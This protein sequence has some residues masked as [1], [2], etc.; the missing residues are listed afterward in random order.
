MTELGTLGVWWANLGSASARQE[1]EAVQEIERMGYGTFW[2]GESMRNKDAMAHAGVLLGATS[3][4]NVASGI[5]SIYNRDATATKSGA[6]FLADASGGRFV[7][8]L[9]VSHA[10]AVTRRGAD[11]GKPVSTMRAYLDEME[12]APYQPPAP[13]IPPPIMLA[14]LRTR[15]L[16][17]AAERTQGA[18]PY[19]TTPDH[20]KRARAALGDGPLLA[21]EQGFVIEEDPEAAREIARAHISYYLELPNYLNNWREDGFTDD[22]FKDGGSDRLVDALVAHGDVS[23]IKTRIQQH[24][25]AG[26]DHVCIQPV[27]T[28]IERGM[29]ELKELSPT[30]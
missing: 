16:K 5:A 17:L 14:A 20:T 13:E 25:D 22:D 2:F 19:L 24:L 26:A 18:H 27:T 3:T 15:M 9:G 28:D 29:R 7:L 1:I 10:P 4:I 6:Y 30:P 12:Q 21:P 11:Y 23:A 8:G